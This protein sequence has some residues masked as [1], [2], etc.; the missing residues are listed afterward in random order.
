MEGPTSHSMTACADPCSFG[1]AHGEGMT[2]HFG[3]KMSL[4]TGTWLSVP[5][6][7]VTP[8]AALYHWYLLPFNSC[9]E[10]SESGKTYG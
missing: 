5:V 1:T 3:G 6:R 10:K 2:L 9:D 4:L 7:G 8:L